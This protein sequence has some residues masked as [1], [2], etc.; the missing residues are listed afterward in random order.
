[1]LLISGM[2]LLFSCESKDFLDETE[3]TDL[4]EMTVFSDS[5]Y[6]TAFLTDIY[7]GIGFSSDP[8]RFGSGGSASGGLQT[9]CDEAEPRRLKDI[10]TDIQFASG[11]VNPVVISD[12]AWN[13]SYEYIRKANQL[14]KHLPNTPLTQGRKKRY[15]AEARFLRA[16]YY[17]ILLKHYGGVPIIGDTIFAMGDEINP[18]RNTY[19]ECVNYIV[20]ECDKAAPEL[21]DR[22]GGRDY[23]RAG[24]VACKALKT[25]VLLYAASPLY[26]GSDFASDLP[27]LK[28][29]VG[30]QIYDKERWRLARDAAREVISTGAYTLYVDNNDEPGRGFY[31]LFMAADWINAGAFSGTILEKMAFKGNGR[32]RLF[33]PPSRNGGGGGWPYQELVD[34]FV[35]KNGKPITDPT[36]G[37]DPNNPYINRDPR[38]KNS[39]IY[40]QAPLRNASTENVPVNIYL[41]NYNGKPQGQDAVHT[42]TPTGY[43]INKMLHRAI[44]AN[45]FIGGP[46]SRPL[47]RYAEVL[48]NYSEAQNEYV[49]PTVEVYDA[50]KSIRERAGIQAGDDGMYG[51]KADMSQAEMREIVRNER[52]VELAIEGHRFWDVRRWMIADQTEDRTMHGMEVRRDGASANYTEFEVRKRVFRKAM[53]LWPI[54]Y[55]EVAKSPKLKQNPYYDNN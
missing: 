29:L 33:Q 4:D 18:T 9:A 48:L 46:Q 2:W 24:S 30:Y 31:R 47:L 51:L 27:E 3:T 10:T 39:I 43:Y 19:E 40:D 14:L 8:N 23:G 38:F 53:Y 54:P 16:W 17:F 12:D 50:L 21:Q 11:T 32:E 44:A 49:G 28:P 42:G 7:T 45:Y 25:R 35:M 26:N 37:Y 52:R 55:K 41:G 36:S 13:R 1:M 34:A 5:T 6:T 15:E 22:P 20:S